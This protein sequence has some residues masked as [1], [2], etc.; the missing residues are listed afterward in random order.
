MSEVTGLLQAGYARDGEPALAQDRLAVTE[1]VLEGAAHSPRF[2]CGDAAVQWLLT[3]GQ[4]ELVPLLSQVSA[5]WVNSGTNLSWRPL[6]DSTPLDQ[7]TVPAAPAAP[8]DG[9][10]V[11]PQIGGIATT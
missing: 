8:G 2:T 1:K 7:V 6:G 9:L 10:R 11:G 4:D 5:A 3:A